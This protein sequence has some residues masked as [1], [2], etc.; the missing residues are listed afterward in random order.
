MKTEVQIV[1]SG[2]FRN[3][4]MF[5]TT[6]MLNVTYPGQPGFPTHSPG[7]GHGQQQDGSQKCGREHLSLENPKCK[8]VHCTVHQQPCAQLTVNGV[9]MIFKRRNVFFYF[10]VNHNQSCLPFSPA[11]QGQV[12]GLQSHLCLALRVCNGGHGGDS[13]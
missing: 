9:E 11:E 3:F 6:H 12:K 10:S 7:C 1:M 8:Y 13:N 5:L 2:Q 4:V